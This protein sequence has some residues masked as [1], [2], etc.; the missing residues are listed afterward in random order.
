[1][2]PFFQN[3]N[4]IPLAGWMIIGF[5]FATLAG[6]FFNV[7]IWRMP[8]GESVVH[9]PSKCPKCQSGIA[10]YDNVPILGWIWLAG[11]CRN[12][13]N[14]IS[15]EYPIV[16]FVTG[17]VGVLMIGAADLWIVDATWA[18]YLVSYTLGLILV[19]VVVIDLRHYL[20]P[21]MMVLPGALI[22]LALASFRQDFSLLDSALG[23]FGVAF[24]LW[25]FA[26]IMSWALKKQAMGFGDVKYMLFAGCILGFQNGILNVILGSLVGLVIIPFLK[27]LGLRD[28]SGKFPFGPMLAVGTLLALF[29]GQEI[30][31]LYFSLIGL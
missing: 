10:W 14:P 25:G 30:W 29:W 12:C 27:I 31:T 22:A 7:V 3:L 1:M 23:G 16:E 4:L 6:S 11:K 17:V 9:P 13:K 20:I 28:L 8:R 18:D 19:P 26:T 2:E 5:I 21:D 24:A 15:P